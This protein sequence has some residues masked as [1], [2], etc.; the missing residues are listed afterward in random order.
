MCT[1]VYF[2]AL[3]RNITSSE[4]LMKSV[5]THKYIYIYIFSDLM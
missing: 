2:N 4:A 3:K 1:W 5:H